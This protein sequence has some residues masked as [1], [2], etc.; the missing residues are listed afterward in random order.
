M[1]AFIINLD[2]ATDR[3]AFIEKSFAQSRL[4]L[5]RVPAIDIKFLTFPHQDYLEGRYRLLHGRI[6][7]RRELACYLSHIKAIETFLATGESH[8][9]IGEDDIVLRPELDAVLEAA[10]RHAPN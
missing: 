5:R 7:N 6:P 10:L 1:Q 9:V 4:E 2:A 8:A 3:W